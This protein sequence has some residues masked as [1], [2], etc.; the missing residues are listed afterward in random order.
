MPEGRGGSGCCCCCR[1]FPA[2]KELVNFYRGSHFQT[3]S[4]SS[5]PQ[6]WR[7]AQEPGKRQPS[8]AD[9]TWPPKPRSPHLLRGAQSNIA[10]STKGQH[11]HHRQGVP[12][13]GRH[14][15]HQSLQKNQIVYHVAAEEL[16][17]TQPPPRP[18]WQGSFHP[19]E[20]CQP[21]W[22]QPSSTLP[23]KPFRG[24]KLAEFLGPTLASVGQL[25]DGAEGLNPSKGQHHPGEE[26]LNLDGVSG[27]FSI[28]SGNVSRTGGGPPCWP[29]STPS[30]AG[31]APLP[32]PSDLC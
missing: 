23:A 32:R 10:Q 11:P 3:C 18:L 31:S 29:R 24:Q 26:S 25:P 14:A 20:R 22:W 19:Q 16:K 7:P 30:S 12:L 1:H 6:R 9:P 5:C 4:R 21:E 28:C 15:V 27:S 2:R 17:D 13:P 8:S